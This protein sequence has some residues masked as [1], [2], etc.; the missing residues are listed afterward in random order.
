[1]VALGVFKQY[2][3]LR[4]ILLYQAALQ[5]E[6]L[7]LAVGKYILEVLRVRDHL[8]DFAVVVFFRPEVLAYAVLKGFGFAYINNLSGFVVHDVHARIKRQAHGLFTQFL[9]TFFVLG[10]S[11]PSILHIRQ[12][13]VT[14]VRPFPRK[15]A[16]KTKKAPHKRCQ[17]KTRLFRKAGLHQLHKAVD[18]FFFVWAVGNYLYGSSSDNSK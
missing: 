5:H 13:P 6:R 12:K 4:H 2:V 14:K 17:V 15:R 18:S 16:E 8:P 9:Y 3:V 1:M 7:K 10:Q 11:E